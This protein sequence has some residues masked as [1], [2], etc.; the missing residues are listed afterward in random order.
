[1]GKGSEIKGRFL[2]LT[3]GW[4]AFINC[5]FASTDTKEITFRLSKAWATLVAAWSTFSQCFI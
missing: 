2:Q 3:E 1:M 4:N 5:H